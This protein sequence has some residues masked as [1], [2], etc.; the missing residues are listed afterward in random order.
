MVKS[1]QIIVSPFSKFG[2]VILYRFES[3]F[4]KARKSSETPLINLLS[5]PLKN[6]LEVIV[7]KTAFEILES[8]NG[9]GFYY[10]NRFDEAKRRIR[11]KLARHS[12]LCAL[13]QAERCASGL[14]EKVNFLR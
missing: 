9:A 4:C 3:I 8:F 11:E 6:P 14:A 7:W 12:Y 5:N 13:W 10:F 1:A 2:S